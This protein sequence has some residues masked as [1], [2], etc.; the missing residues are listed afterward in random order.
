MPSYSLQLVTYDRGTY[1]AGDR[2]GKTKPFH[3]SF[4]IQ[5][6]GAP[7]SNPGVAMQLRGMPGAF[8]YKGPENVDMA[9]SRSRKEE[10]EIGTLSGGSLEQ[11]VAAVDRLLKRVRIERD[12]SSRWNCQSWALDG[13]DDLA[14]HPN[15]FTAYYD[16]RAVKAWL[17]TEPGR[18]PTPTGG[19]RPSS[20]AGQAQPSS[21]TS[22]PPSR[23]GDRPP[24]RTSERPPSRTSERPPSR[25]G[26][27]PSSRSGDRPSSRASNTSLSHNPWA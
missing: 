3:W 1:T 12:E 9:R 20:R 26:E 24:S 27:R 7:G 21:S 14:A 8:Y 5:T 15:L 16:R 6:P 22:R 2:K 17:Q 13:F 23:A 10:L 4:F 18:T 11:I 19:S 25:A